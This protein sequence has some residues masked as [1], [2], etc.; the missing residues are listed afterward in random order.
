MGSTNYFSWKKGK[1]ISLQVNGRNISIKIFLAQALRSVL[2][3]VVA[4]RH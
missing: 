2:Q 1:T 3:V 4:L